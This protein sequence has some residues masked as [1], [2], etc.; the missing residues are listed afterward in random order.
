MTGST[1]HVKNIA[2]S[3]TETELTNFFSFCG[4]ITAHTLTPE[5]GAPDSPL[6]A[7]IT[8][9]SPSAASTAVLLDGT[10]LNHVP[11]Q[12]TAAHSIEEIA[13]SHLAPTAAIG[14]DGEIPQEA[15]P[16]STIFAEYL[17]SGYL[18][19]DT[20]L[21]KGIELDK[22][23]QITPKFA[24]ALTSAF[25][26]VENKL[27]AT[28]RARAVN[29]QY[30]VTE[31]AWGFTGGLARYFEK[32]LDNPTGQKVRHFYESSEKQILDIHTEAKR[33]AELK[34]EKR[35]SRSGSQEAGFA[36]SCPGITGECSCEPGSCKCEGCSNKMAAAAAAKEP[37]PA[38]PAVD[39][40]PPAY[41]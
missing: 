15:K 26:F 27:G 22:K 33:L 37:T 29:E 41:A 2:S 40:K 4:K 12:V 9:N 13:G 19:G 6:S 16:R 21:H 14:P 25:N 24:G 34:K 17:A 28:Q 35:R 39:E 20:A 36:C 23:H 32:A 8:F 1:V 3:T 11:L 38:K 31:K 18:I 7:T 30:H 5:S 10:P